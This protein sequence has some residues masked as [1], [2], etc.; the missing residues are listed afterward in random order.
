MKIPYNATKDSRLVSVK[1]V[2]RSSKK[3]IAAIEGD[4]V[5]IK[6]TAPPVDGAA[7]EQVIEIIAEV[8]NAKKSDV[9]IIRG[10][11]S[12]MKT[13]RIKGV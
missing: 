1:V 12:R 4:V 13:V 8:M 3:G 7:N 11:A 9:D 5:K 10:S 6:V 2:P